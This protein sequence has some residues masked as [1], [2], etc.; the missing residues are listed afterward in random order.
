VEKW[1]IPWQLAVSG[2][3]DYGFCFIQMHR[4]VVSWQNAITRH[5]VDRKKEKAGGSKEY[6][7]KLGNE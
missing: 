5:L 4:R 3:Y 6:E 2:S 1:R 7:N